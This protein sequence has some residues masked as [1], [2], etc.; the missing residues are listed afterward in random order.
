MK[1]L[2]GM[3]APYLG[4][5][6]VATLADLNVHNFTHPCFVPKGKIFA[7]SSDPGRDALYQC[8]PSTSGHRS[9]GTSCPP[10]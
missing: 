1:S 6:L 5:D 8:E 3:K 9:D 7:E 4:S 2:L 10:V